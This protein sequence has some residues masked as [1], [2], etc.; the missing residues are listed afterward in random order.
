MPEPTSHDRL[1]R[2]ADFEMD[3]QACELRR[4]G[5]RIPLQM[6]P[7][8][9]LETLIN[10][11]GEVVS[12]ASLS[13]AIWP[14]K[15]FID[16]DHGLN[17]AV[18]RLRQALDD[19][20]DV[21]RYIE[22]LPR[23][24]YRFIH[25]L[26]P[27]ATATAS[28][29][30]MVTPLSADSSRR[31]PRRVLSAAAAAAALIAVAAVVVQRKE[32]GE[33][34]ARSSPASVARPTRSAE[35]YDAYLRGIKLREP[36][37]KEAQTLS[38]EH[39][40]RATKLDP[41]FAEAHAELAAAY[42]GAGGGSYASFLTAGEALRLALVAAQRALQLDPNLAV[43]HLALA[44]VLSLQPQSAPTDMA[45]EQAYRR[46]LE[47]DGKSAEAHLQ[48]GNYLSKRQRS[49]EAL[50]QFQLALELDPLSP[51]VNSRLGEELMGTGRT[52]EGLKY[53][54]KT[55]E[56][57][58]FQFNARMRLGWAYMSV[59]KM[60]DANREIMAAD[61]ISPNSTS[62]LS[63]L[64]FIAAQHGNTTRARELLKIVLS[65]ANSSSF[66]LDVTIIYVGLKDRDNALA[67]LAKTVRQ[68]QALHRNSPWSL[69]APMYDWLRGDP[70]FKELE[71]EIATAR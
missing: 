36:R 45:I 69:A 41:N 15:V 32:I 51:S 57:Y 52:A 48:F 60:D 68:T 23:I 26:T 7:F 24:G 37:N 50:A 61:R 12:R 31:Q 13:A 65:K 38:I 64:A 53:L 63:G 14:G 66:P 29:P 44:R 59:G 34:A 25:T 40:T 22:T 6:Q 39:L 43:A 49:A 11:A 5:Q 35:A 3:R 8:R 10:H 20:G 28:Q 56:L 9:V 54:R 30:A 67:W 33:P 58:P 17:N 21:P 47:L 42:A 46:A 55:V 16:T 18:N 27:Q 70:R 62:S 19:S 1:V 71:R 4:N 2:F